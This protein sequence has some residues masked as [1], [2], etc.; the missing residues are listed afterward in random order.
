MH[1]FS[2]EILQYAL[3]V[4]QKSNNSQNDRIVQHLL[5]NTHVDLLNRNNL[6][7]EHI[8]QQ[9]KIKLLM[10]IFTNRTCIFRII[11]VFRKKK[12]RK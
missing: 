1:E 12:D 10:R 8:L 7:N 9:Y 3:V 6:H 5:Q 4:L 11:K 2:I